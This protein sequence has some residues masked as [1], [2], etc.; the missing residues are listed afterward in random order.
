MWPAFGPRKTEGDDIHQQLDKINRHLSRL[1][2]AV[3]LHPDEPWM[4][5]VFP[6]PIRQFPSRSVPVVMW[7]FALL[8]T[9]YAAE[10][11]MSSGRPDGGWFHPN[12]VVDGF[13]GYALPVLGVILVASFVHKSIASYYGIRVPHLL[14]IFAFPATWWPFGL[15]G[16]VS[17]PRMDARFWPNR[18]ALG[19]SA[20]SVPLIMISTGMIFVLWGDSP[21]S[22]I[23]GTRIFSTTYRITSLCTILL[24]LGLLG[25]RAMLL[26]TVFVHPLTYAGC[27]LVFSAGYLSFPF[28]HSP[29]ADSSWQEWV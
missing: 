15:L 18:A 10:T 20:I 16:V 23:N 17:I 19:W 25:E 9:L 8:S 6:L 13:L 14:P 2:W 26:G 22:I 3:G 1:D 11:W 7:F 5:H 24:G 28:L 29:E 12:I 27:T 21:L 4:M